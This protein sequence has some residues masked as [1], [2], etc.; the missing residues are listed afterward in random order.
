MH[1]IVGINGATGLEIANEL[2]RRNIPVRGVSR[3]SFPGHWEHVQADAMQ[4]D[5]LT[6]ALAGATTVYSCVGLEYN[7]KIW[8]RDWPV[9]IEN[10]I[11][12]CLANNAQLIF[13]DNVYMYG[14]VQG[15]MTEN[16][17]MN[18]TSQKGIVRKQVAE[19]LLHAFAQRGLRGCIARSADFYGPNCEKSMIA[20][21][22]FK[23]VA[24]G[25]TM[26]W[27]GRIE[28][29]HA[30]TYTPDIG[31]ACVN[32]ATSNLLHGDVWHLPTAKAITAHEFTAMVAQSLGVPPK[33]M[34]L[35]GFLLTVLSLFIPILREIKE[36]M[37]QY[38]EDYLF[39]SE[40]Y[41]KAF[42]EQPTPYAVGIPVVVA[43]EKNK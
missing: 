7:I 4:R 15:E 24:K 41:E 35:R 9:L 33:V 25:R 8:Q 10:L 1:T 43:S 12:A 40:K 38:D 2:Q 19:T 16:T 13:I 37:Y 36:M 31:R 17:P 28:K 5:Q 39:S 26:Q 6:K 30:F 34:A 42:G 23:N 27:L 3:R 20:E 18:P 32:L 11:L 14:F 21:S 29:R 22:V